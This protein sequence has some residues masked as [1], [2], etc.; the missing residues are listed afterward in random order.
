MKLMTMTIDNVSA[1]CPHCKQVIALPGPSC[2]RVFAL[3]RRHMDACR[4]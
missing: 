2:K 3:M 1:T 4:G